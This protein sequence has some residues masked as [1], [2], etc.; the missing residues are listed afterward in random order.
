ME[1][2]TPNALTWRGDTWEL[3]TDFGPVSWQYNGCGLVVP[4]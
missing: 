3:F 2:F 4:V 1:S